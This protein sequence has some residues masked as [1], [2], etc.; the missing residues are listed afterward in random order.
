MV[1]RDFRPWQ[2]RAGRPKEGSVK[3]AMWDVEIVLVWWK[4]VSAEGGDPTDRE[5]A[6]VRRLKAF[7]EN[8]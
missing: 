8:G 1:D 2:E 6:L 3:L 5:A 4:R 7:T